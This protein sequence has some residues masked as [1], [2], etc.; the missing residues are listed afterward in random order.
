MH[1][2]MWKQS[3]NRKINETLSSRIQAH[4]L[5]T[6]SHRLVCPLILLGPFVSVLGADLEMMRDNDD[7]DE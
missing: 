6:S 7:D 3:L 2:M 5:V 1:G 4:E